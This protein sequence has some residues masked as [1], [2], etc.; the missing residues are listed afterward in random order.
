MDS[1]LDNLIAAEHGEKTPDEDENEFAFGL[2]YPAQYVIRTW[3]EHRKNGLYPKGGGYD[4][5]DAQLMDDWHMMDMRLL[6]RSREY[7]ASKQDDPQYPDPSN[8]KNWTEL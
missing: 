6:L 1:F 8:A 4:D 7:D 3:Y 5:Q 2:H